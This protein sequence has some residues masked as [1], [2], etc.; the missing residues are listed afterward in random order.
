MTKLTIT[1]ETLQNA[2]KNYSGKVIDD[3]TISAICTEVD[4]LRSV[5]T[6]EPLPVLDSS[7][8]AGVCGEAEKEA[9]GEEPADEVTE[10]GTTPEAGDESPVDD[11]DPV[12]EAEIK[13]SKPRQKMQK[14]V[15]LH[16]P[17]GKLVGM[18][19]F[20]A[21]PIEIPADDPPDGS[22]FNR[23]LLDAV[24]EHNES[25]RGRKHPATSLR[26]SIESIPYEYLRPKGIKTI[27]E[28]SVFVL[29]RGS[30]LP[31]L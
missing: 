17:E 15:V 31:T 28:T 27:T 18:G 25:Q 3:G 20:M 5:G 24:N 19:D 1:I 29:V 12:Q 7:T 13:V 14:I 30:E 16:D 11:T 2:L 9:E 6:D 4:R 22:T 8:V 10:L 26:E 21:W 23:R